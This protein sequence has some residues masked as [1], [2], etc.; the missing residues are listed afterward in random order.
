[1]TKRP[2][3]F[4]IWSKERK[5]MG[6][7]DLS[8]SDMGD[9]TWLDEDNIMQFTGLLDKNGTKIFE[10]DIVNE[11]HHESPS[12]VVEYNDGVFVPFGDFRSDIFYVIGNIYQNPELL[13]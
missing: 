4:R 13:T 12:F 1:M 11:N 7:I 9:P 2:I 5:C 8:S 10:G 3:E 6:Y